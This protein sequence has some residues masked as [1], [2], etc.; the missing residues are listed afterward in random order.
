M[1]GRI[2]FAGS[3]ITDE[4]LVATEDV[5]G[6]EAVVIVVAVEEAAFLMTVNFVV[7]GIEVQD[8]FLGWCFEGSD[9]LLDEHLVDGPCT[10]AVGTVFPTAKS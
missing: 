7:S 5:Q 10:P 8:E 2:D 4:E 6:Q 9:E 3:E 1:F